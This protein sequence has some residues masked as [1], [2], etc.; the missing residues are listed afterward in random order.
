MGLKFLGIMPDTPVTDSPTIW[1]EEGTGDLIIQ[2]YKADDETIS[3]AQR[4]GSILGHST[5]IP[6]HETV[7][8]LPAVMRQHLPHEAG[9]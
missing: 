3:E 9:E 5:Q 4:V 6:E 8:R 2:S 7:I 1:L